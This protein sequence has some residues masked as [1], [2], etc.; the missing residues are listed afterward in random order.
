MLANNAFETLSKI[1]CKLFLTNTS[2]LF[3]VTM[4]SKGYIKLE[5]RRNSD[6]LVQE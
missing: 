1:H 6:I 5:A 4:P 3:Q 2:V